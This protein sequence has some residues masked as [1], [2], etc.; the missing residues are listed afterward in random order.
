MAAAW[1]H[2]AP[3]ADDLP[4]ADRL[5]GAPHPRETARLF[6]QAAAEAGFRAARAQ[7][8]LHHAWLLTGPRGTGKATFAWAAARLLLDDGS[9]PALARRIRALAEPRLFLLR[10]GP[11]ERG[12]A[13]SRFITVE[14]ARR[15]RGFLGLSA[16]DGGARVVIVDSVDDMNANAANAL[17]KL[18]E[19]PPPGAF[20]LLVSHQPARLLPTIR[21]RCRE[22]RFQPLAPPDLAAALEQA[23]APALAPDEG[24]ALGELASGSVGEAFLLAGRDGLASYRALVALL[25]RLPRLDR[26]ALLSLTGEAAAR[27]PEE[28]FDLLLGQI[29]HFLARLARTGATGTP[30]PEA[31]RGEAALLARLAADAD[32]ARRWADLALAL[33][34]RA[35]A[36]QAVNLDLGALLMDTLLQI[37]AAAGATPAG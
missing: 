10:R 25:S 6:G 32:A 19:E 27:A 14:E 33:T 29:D 36:G 22:L 8:R 28:G 11:N 34:R 23:G 31:A 26:A 3:M 4:E 15:L 21:S 12:N 35:R 9:D 30:P 18:L 20:F 5:P 37:E 24:V 16:A 17:L 7:G 1:R 13:L 2:H